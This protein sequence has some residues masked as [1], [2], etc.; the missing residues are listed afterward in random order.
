MSAHLQLILLAALPALTGVQLALG[1]VVSVVESPEFARAP[2][3]LVAAVGGVAELHCQVL[4]LADKSVSWVRSKD[5]HIL[6]HAGAV[7]TA[8][9]R[10]SVVESGAVS[11]AG[12]VTRQTLRIEKLRVSDGGRY[13]CQVNTEPKMSQFFN[14]TVVD[15]VVPETVVSA[16]GA[17]RRRVARGGAAT[18][19]C[20][21]RYEPPPRDLPLP[22]LDIHWFFGD[23]P[24]DLQSARG[25]VSLDTERWAARS[26]SRLTLAALAPRDAGLYRCA[27]GDVADT[28]QLSVAD[29]TE[30]ALMEAMQ[31]DQSAMSSGNGR[32]SVVTSS[33]L[34]VP[35]TLLLFRR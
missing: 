31:R 32:V 3:P 17:R 4:R 9:P 6:S 30:G 34:T 20:E 5:L 1:E 28:L 33:L 14:L 12:G 23:Q 7:F 27:A 26:V 10:V 18:L 8:D 16:V 21:A 13:E 11:G 22:T 2:P 29:Y 15:E 24:I 25:G 19:V 35:L